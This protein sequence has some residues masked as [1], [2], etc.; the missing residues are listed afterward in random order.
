MLLYAFGSNDR[1][2][3]TGVAEWQCLG[4]RKATQA[5]LMFAGN[6]MNFF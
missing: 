1:K 2:L 6:H 4:G 5:G 3:G